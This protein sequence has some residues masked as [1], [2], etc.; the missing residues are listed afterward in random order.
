MFQITINLAK[1]FQNL[2]ISD[3]IFSYLTDWVGGFTC[4]EPPIERFFLLVLWA[5]IFDENL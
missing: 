3:R 4:H 5:K 2:E 1:N